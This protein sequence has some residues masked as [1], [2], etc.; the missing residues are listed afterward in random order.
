MVNKL[1]S[2]GT[3]VLFLEIIFTYMYIYTECCVS[4]YYIYCIHY[5]HLI[6][7][8]VD[9]DIDNNNQICLDRIQA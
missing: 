6:I 3:E 8:L 7:V 2:E 5:M 1:N 4:R 9:I